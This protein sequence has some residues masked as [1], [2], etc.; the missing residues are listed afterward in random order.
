MKEL[1]AYAKKDLNNHHGGMV[2][3]GEY[4]YFGHDQNQGL[5]V[6]VEFKTGD[7]KWGPEKKSRSRCVGFRSGSLRRWPTLLPLSERRD[8]ADRA[9]AGRVEGGVVVQVA[10]AGRQNLCAELAAPGHC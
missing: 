9:V 4:I 1:K 3:I 7:I 10:C 5:P 2:L 6:C 8:G